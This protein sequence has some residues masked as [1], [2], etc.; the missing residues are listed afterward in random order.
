MRRLMRN[1]A[2]GRIP[3]LPT[4]GRQIIDA[5]LAGKAGDQHRP[6]QHNAPLAHQ[7]RAIAF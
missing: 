5:G 6:P 7:D 1:V 3:E 4:E 2:G